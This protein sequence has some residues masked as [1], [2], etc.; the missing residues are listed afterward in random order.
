MVGML[1][2]AAWVNLGLRVPPGAT[3]PDVKL[4][5]AK[6]AIDTLTFIR[7]QLQATMEEVEKREMDNLIGTLQMNYVRR[8]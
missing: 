5:E 8:T 3:E 2:E 7:D 1:S 4:P 6:L